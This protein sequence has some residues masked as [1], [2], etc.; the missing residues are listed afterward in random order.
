AGVKPAAVGAAPRFA[1]HA[2]RGLADCVGIDASHPGTCPRNRD[3][4]VSVSTSTFHRTTMMDTTP[5]GVGTG[6]PPRRIPLSPTAAV[7]L[8]ISI[9]LCGGY[10]DL[11]VMCF[12]KSFWDQDGYFRTGRDFLWTV[13]VGHAVLLIFVA[14]LLAVVGRRRHR[15][16]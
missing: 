6:K 1:A 10:L 12:V 3:G 15:A 7:L 13:P 5:S 16:P 2:L 11:L 9:G 8:A 14:V 4:P